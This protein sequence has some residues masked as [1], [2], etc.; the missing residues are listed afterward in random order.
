MSGKQ[1]VIAVLVV[2]MWILGGSSSAQEENN[3]VTGM[4]GRIF[5][6]DQGLLNEPPPF[7]YVHFGKGLSFEASYAR[8]FLVTPIFAIS[9]EVPELFNFDEKLFPSY[10]F[11][12]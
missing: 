10:A 7:N 4:I 6:S 3:E 2:T 8:R 5:I 12:L 1:A 9:G 11:F